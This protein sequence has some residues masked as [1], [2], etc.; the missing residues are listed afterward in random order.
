MKNLI[1]ILLL[2]SYYGFGQTKQPSKQDSKTVNVYGGTN[3]F[4][5]IYGNITYSYNFQD[6]E[7]INKFLYDIKA[8]IPETSKLLNDILK[9]SQEDINY[10]KKNYELAQKNYEL[11]QKFMEKSSKKDTI[12]EEKV[13][14][15]DSLNNELNKYKEKNI[16]L[17]NQIREMKSQTKESDF[18]DVLENANENLK[19]NDNEEYQNVLENYITKQEI[20][21]NQ[22]KSNIAKAA[23]LQAMNSRMNFD[24]ES[25]LEQINKAIEYDKEN[26]NYLFLKAEVLFFKN[27]KLYDD[28]SKWDEC[29]NIF[30][31]IVDVSKND[32]IIS[33][34]YSKI[35]YIY[36]WKIEPDK[37]IDY[38]SK[39]LVLNEKLY[40]KNHMETISMD[41]LLAYAYLG[42]PDLNKAKEYFLKHLEYSEKEFGKISTRTA[43]SYKNLGDVYMKKYD[44]DNALIY[45]NKAL[46]INEK[47]F[48]EVNRRTAD[49]YQLIGYVYMRKGDKENAEK[50]YSKALEIREKIFKEDDLNRADAYRTISGYYHY[51]K[52]YNNT[53]VYLR[54]AI[55]I[56]EKVKGKDNSSLM[57]IYN[58]IGTTLIEKGDKEEGL[59]YLQKFGLP[60]PLKEQSRGL[61]LWGESDMMSNKYREAINFFQL[62]LE[63]L[64]DG[65]IPKADT[66][67]TTIRQN[68][69]CSNCII[70][71]INKTIPLIE[72]TNLFSKDVEEEK[73]DYRKIKNECEACKMK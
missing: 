30:L 31:K 66:L 1:F 34:S 7:Q 13:V 60:K 73:I 53:I 41:K 6:K 43:D 14:N 18:A 9:L 16:L 4:I 71:N 54:K 12:N 27:E 35:G 61:N 5:M 2:V 62:A 48:G 26:V 56:Y 32:T 64:E 39:A 67:Y 70:E 40:G 69:A 57:L 36:R 20:D 63:L 38:A 23:Y 51:E 33:D 8:L 52:D 29:L 17:Q 55:N 24:Y 37:I 42:I 11:F 68:I 3:N 28:R 21:V 15:I 47:I 72:N 59:K 45:Y 22:I 44:K 49:S 65:N 46:E 25:A 10:S 19:R 58:S 50:Y